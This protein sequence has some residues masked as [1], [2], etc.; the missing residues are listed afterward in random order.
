MEK[1]L[2]T[3]LFDALSAQYGD[4]FYLLDSARFEQNCRELDAAFR[5]YYPRSRI[6]YS[7]K[8]NYT[9]RLA[10]VVDRLGAWAEVVSDMELEIALRSGVDARHIIWNG[11]VKDIQKACELL[12][13]GGLVNVDT[14]GELEELCTVARAQAGRPLGI[15]LRCNYDVGDGVISRFGFDVESDEFDSALRMLS[16]GRGLYLRALQAHFARRDPRLWTAR[17][18]GMLRIYDRVSADYDMR[19]EILDLGGGIFGSMPESLR[20]QLGVGP[21]EFD[22]YASRAA[23]LFADHFRSQ[24]D[25]PT[26]FIEPGTALAGDSMRFVTKVKTIKA[27]RGKTFA[28][29][30][31][32]QKNVSMSGVNPP[33]EIVPGGGEQKLYEGLDVVGYTCIEGDVLQRNY[34]GELAVGDYVVI[35]NCGS[36]SLVMKPPFILPNFPVLDIGGTEPEL[37]K[38]GEGF[39]NLFETF[40]FPE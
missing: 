12:S 16:E 15:G 31:G 29:T 28:T 1:T 39:E 2:N 27:V 19:P 26:L 38:R 34:C 9:P 7:Y 22:D 20:L 14:L 37:V 4:S 40:I 36:Y 25:A 5:R 23:G 21:F 35:G 8:T 10:R 24:P 13:A 3:A 32:S 6:A 18:A 17:A 11:P 33:M 30:F